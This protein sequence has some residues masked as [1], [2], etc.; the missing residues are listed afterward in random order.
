VRILYEC[1]DFLI[2]EK[3]QGLDSEEKTGDCLPRRL[4]AL[5]A[6]RGERADIYPVHRLDRPTGGAIVYARTPYAAAALSKV[7]A[8]RRM[9]KRY[10]AVIA[11]KPAEEIG[12][13]RDFLY[14]DKRTNK[15][16]VVKEG[17]KG[18]KEARLGYRVLDS[19]ETAEGILSLVQIILYTGRTHQIRAQFASRRM[20][21]Y[22]DRRYGSPASLSQ[23]RIAL[24]SRSIAFTLDDD[25]SVTSMPPI[26]ERPWE[27]FSVLASVAA[28]E[29]K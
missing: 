21:V 22:G 20:P 19:R 6:E 24:W 1:A 12:E 10:L 8:E 25:I 29:E 5:L 14:H 26:D 7:V 27:Y 11:G 23:G 28:E 9:D 3:P 17:K 2:V 15:V 13:M 16:F 4:S 18:A